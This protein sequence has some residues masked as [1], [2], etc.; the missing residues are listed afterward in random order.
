MFLYIDPNHKPEM[1]V[2]VTDFEALC[3]FRPVYDIIQ[4]IH[5][6]PEFQDVIGEEGEFLLF[7]LYIISHGLYGLAIYSDGSIAQLF[8]CC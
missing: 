7:I 8:C 1:L 6:Y 3:G 2:A 5:L 4:Y